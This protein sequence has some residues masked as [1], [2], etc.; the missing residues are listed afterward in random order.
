MIFPLL[1][2]IACVPSVFATGT[3]LWRTAVREDKVLRP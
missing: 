2:A 1:A 3:N